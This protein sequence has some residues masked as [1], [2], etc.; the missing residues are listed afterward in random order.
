MKVQ[1]QLIIL[2]SLVQHAVMFFELN[3]EMNVTTHFLMCR[4]SSLILTQNFTRI[5]LGL[6]WRDS[7]KDSMAMRIEERGKKRESRYMVQHE[8]MFFELVP[9]QNLLQ[10][11]LP[12]QANKKFQ[13]LFLL[14]VQKILKNKVH[15][16]IT[17]SKKS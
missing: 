1:S 7:K 13:L 8:V 17:L 2:V 5:T 12:T 9:K 3:S 4:V 10:L 11:C 16:M 6:M 15:K 14:L